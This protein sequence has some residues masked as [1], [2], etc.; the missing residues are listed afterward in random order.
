MEQ[1][2][3]AQAVS[4]KQMWTFYQD[5]G[6]AELLLA[7]GASPSHSS[8]AKTDSIPNTW[9]VEGSSNV[10]SSYVEEKVCV[11]VEEDIL[12]EWEIVEESEVTMLGRCLDVEREKEGLE[13][14]KCLA[15]CL[16]S[17]LLKEVVALAAA[18]AEALYHERLSEKASAAMETEGGVPGG[19][20]PLSE[21]DDKAVGDDEEV[22]A[23]D[24]EEG[25]AAMKSGVSQEVPGDFPGNFEREL[26]CGLADQARSEWIAATAT[27]ALTKYLEIT[28]EE[29]C[30]ADCDGNVADSSGGVAVLQ[31][32]LE[33]AS[34]E[35]FFMAEKIPEEG[36]SSDKLYLK[37]FDST[38]E[39]FVGTGVMA[40]GE[41]AVNDKVAG[42]EVVKDE[43]ANRKLVKDHLI[44]GDLDRH[45]S[46]LDITPLDEHLVA[47]A[48]TPDDDALIPVS[49]FH[50]PSLSPVTLDAATM[51]NP[52]P[53]PETSDIETN[54]VTIMLMDRGCSPAPAPPIMT[55][56]GT[57]TVLSIEDLEARVKEKKELELLKVDLHV[58]QSNL[59]QERS[60]R[61]VSEELVKII[62][63]DL[64]ATSGRNTTEVMARLQVEN[65]LTEVKVCVCVCVCIT[66]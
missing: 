21:V 32:V 34:T 7:S 46:D 54:T 4:A 35:E 44:L 50:V 2:A 63:S 58:T 29:G 16:V 56:D 52:T 51:T 41:L 47:K 10:E 5:A 39:H 42:V 11:V 25:K 18:G 9:A 14:E 27:Q 12:E 40:A 60:Q 43:A 65:E 62:Q 3:A 1:V 38:S 57:Q 20:V 37:D 59:N 61:L 17:E 33:E 64:N 45:E 6:K 53:L 23:D 8:S 26:A 19:G 66:R 48:T 13:R 55:H 49:R 24:N 15:E 30:A 22:H 31:R 28:S 36:D